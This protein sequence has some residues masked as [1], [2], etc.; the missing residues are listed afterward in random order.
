[1]VALEELEEGRLGA[2]GA[3]AA[4]E[5]ERLQPVGELLHV[6]P[7]VL[8]PEGGPLPDGGELRRLEVG[9]RQAGQGRRPDGERLQRAQHRDQPAQQE[10]EPVAHDQQVGVVGDERAGGAEVQERPGRGRLLAEGVHV[11]HHV[12]PEAAL[13]PGRGGEIGVVQVGPHLGQR[14]LGNG[15]AQ[16]ALRF[17][18]GQPEP[19]PQADA[20][21]LA[22]E[23][24]HRGRG[25]AGAQ[26]R[27]PAVVA[28]RKT[29]SVKVI[30][31]SRSR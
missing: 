31:P 19:A 6:E 20:V 25:V 30:C 5:P 14:L 22:P 29:R 12:V 13:V 15:E 23:R 1:M 8:H 3:L 2:G 11:R 27:A 21:R 17:R 24:L 4:A 9:V 26:R 10:P 16:L 18:Q 7:E 28:H